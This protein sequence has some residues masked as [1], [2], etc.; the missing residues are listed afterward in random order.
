MALEPKKGYL[1]V[2]LIEARKLAA[3]DVGGGSGIFLFKNYDDYFVINFYIIL[4]PYAV[5]GLLN[6]KGDQVIKYN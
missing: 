5:V 4:D 1:I 2:K 3:K 6:S